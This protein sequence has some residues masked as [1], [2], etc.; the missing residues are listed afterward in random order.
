MDLKQRIE[1]R[2]K[3]EHGGKRRRLARYEESARHGVK[4]LLR[5]LRSEEICCEK[6][7]SSHCQY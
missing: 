2:K 3:Y 1:N 5:K 4:Q 7:E 6:E